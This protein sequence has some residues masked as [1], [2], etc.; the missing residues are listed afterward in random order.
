MTSRII[1]SFATA[2]VFTALANPVS[3]DEK[4]AG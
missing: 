3:A 4:F 1:L 2:I